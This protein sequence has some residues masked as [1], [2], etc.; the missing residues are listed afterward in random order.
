MDTI[1]EVT[2]VTIEPVWHGLEDYKYLKTVLIR[3]LRSKKELKV[4][5]RFLNVSPKRREGWDLG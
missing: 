2:L 4:E 5:M 3:V 1:V